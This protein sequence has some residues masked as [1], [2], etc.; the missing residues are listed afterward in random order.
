MLGQMF[1][2]IPKI[3]LH[4]VPFTKVSMLQVSNFL[5]QSTCP[6][7]FCAVPNV[8]RQT[9]IELHLVPLKNVLYWQKKKE[10]TIQKLSFG[11]AQ[12]VWDCTMN[13]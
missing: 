2:A 8:F 5:C 12:K 9:K 11:P 7:L 3:D 10:F 6:K 13:M 4:I 1:G